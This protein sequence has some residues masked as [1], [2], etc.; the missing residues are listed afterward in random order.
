MTDPQYKAS[1]LANYVEGELVGDDVEVCGLATLRGAGVEHLSFLANSRYR[2]SLKQSSAGVVLVAAHDCALVPNSAI[3]VDNPYL[4]YAKISQLFQPTCRFEGTAVSAFIAVDAIVSESARVGPGAVIESCAEIGE[5]VSIGA[6]AVVGAGVKIG[7]DTHIAPNV[8]LYPSVVIG[9]RCL[10]HSGAVVGSDGFGF[11]PDNGR[12]QKIAQLGR[13]VIGN[14][15]E[16][17]ANTTIDRGALEDTR[18]E[19]GV[20]LD[21][22]IQIAHNV[23]IG[24]GTAIAGGCAVAGSTRIGKQCTIAGMSGITGHLDI[25]DGTHITAMTLVSR[26]ISEAGAYSSGTALEP[27]KQWKRNAVR[28]RQLDRLTKRISELEKLLEQL[29]SEGRK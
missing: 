24:E 9:E 14:D 15:V 29:S 4:A 5:N 28:F 17:G 20:K 11:A 7:A 22:Q 13:V 12:W 10:I 6:N 21:N 18:I 16:I 27:H 8:T 1:Y 3:V 19:D 25:A 2:Q 23:I 26:S